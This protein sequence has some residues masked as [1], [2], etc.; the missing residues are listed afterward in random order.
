[1]ALRLAAGMSGLALAWALTASP[2]GRADEPS[3]TTTAVVTRT[4]AARVEGLNVW[5]W[6]Y[7]AVRNRRVRN[8]QHRELGRLRR[9]Q[10]R[11]WQ[12]TLAGAVRLASAVT[13]VPEWQ[14]RKVAYCESTDDPFASNG[15]H[16]GYWQLSWSPFGLSPYDPYAAALSTAIT[17]RHDGGWRQWRA[18][19]ACHGLR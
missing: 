5:Q 19:I 6:R 2:A 18:S 14:L 10:A 1:M 13:H 11:T 3:P 15:T 16:W 17:V 9:T 7:R 12:P 4:V 8:R